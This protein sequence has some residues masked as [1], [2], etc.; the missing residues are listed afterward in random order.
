MDPQLSALLASDP[1]GLIR[2]DNDCS[3]RVFC[4]KFFLLEYLNV[5]LFI[6][7]WALII[8]TFQ[9]TEC[10]QAP[11]SSDKGGLLYLSVPNSHILH[12]QSHN[13]NKSCVGHKLKPTP[14]YHA[15]ISFLQQ[16]SIKPMAI[17]IWLLHV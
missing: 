9:F 16:C 11:M 1:S 12:V 10:T 2:L 7:V 5:F 13:H 17:K 14:Q 8:Q 4:W 6:N 15:F 3:I